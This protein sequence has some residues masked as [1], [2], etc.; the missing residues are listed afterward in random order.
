MLLVDFTQNDIYLTTPLCVS[1]T[2]L[3]AFVFVFIIPKISK[4]N[5]KKEKLISSSAASETKRSCLCVSASLKMIEKRMI[6]K[7]M[8]KHLLL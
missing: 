1:M 8:R 2:V 3:M 5:E 7:Y 4:L 6:K